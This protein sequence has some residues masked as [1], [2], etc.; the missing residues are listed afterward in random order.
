MLPAKIWLEN[1]DALAE[2]RVER[3]KELLMIFG[4]CSRKQFR[5]YRRLNLKNVSRR[6]MKEIGFRYEKD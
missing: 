1:Y 3:V 2:G 6:N 5:Y 4:H